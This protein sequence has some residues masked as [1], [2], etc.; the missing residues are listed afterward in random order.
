MLE[1]LSV[2]ALSKIFQRLAPSVYGFG[3]LHIVVDLAGN[4]LVDG[5]AVLADALAVVWNSNCSSYV[6]LR[7]G[8]QILLLTEEDQDLELIAILPRPEVLERVRALSREML[9]DWTLVSPAQ[10]KP[11]VPSLIAPVPYHRPELGVAVDEHNICYLANYDG[12]GTCI[13][14]TLIDGAVN[15]NL[16]PEATLLA[17]SFNV[18]LL[19]L[20][21]RQLIAQLSPAERNQYMQAVV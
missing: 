16:S 5:D 12:S 6:L 18:V 11:G 19:P 21:A 7:D 13:C 20:V 17:E 15:A 9:H 10:A 3:F 1:F 8:R 2:H 14:G 4:V